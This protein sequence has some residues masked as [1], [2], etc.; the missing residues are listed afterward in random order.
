MRSIE[1]EIFGMLEKENTKIGRKAFDV[2]NR[3]GIAGIIQKEDIF[4][5]ESWQ[6]GNDCPKAVYNYLKRFIKR[7]FNLKYLYDI[8]EG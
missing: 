1:S 6:I 2:L 3:G 4:W 7:K 8:T 5:F